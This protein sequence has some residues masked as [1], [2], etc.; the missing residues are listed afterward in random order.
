[1]AERQRWYGGPGYLRSGF[2]GG[3]GG[4]VLAGR[5]CRYGVR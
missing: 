4:S 2:G 3:R 1:M 5:L